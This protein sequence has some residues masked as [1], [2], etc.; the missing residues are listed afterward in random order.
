MV[1]PGL[2]GHEAMTGTPQADWA[3]TVAEQ[4]ATVGQELTRTHLLTGSQ[5]WRVGTPWH[6][7]AVHRTPLAP[8]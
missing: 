2:A 5:R 3:G 1:R 8:A 7:D 4:T 6:G